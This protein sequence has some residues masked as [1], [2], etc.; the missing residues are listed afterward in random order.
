MNCI[1]IPHVVP[2]TDFKN[3]NLI[4]ILVSMNEFKTITSNC[5]SLLHLNIFKTYLEN[6]QTILIYYQFKPAT[7]PIPFTVQYPDTSTC[8]LITET[9]LDR[10][11]L[12]SH[13]GMMEKVNMLFEN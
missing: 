1:H 2:V 3:K 11:T 12:V 6:A 10:L 5:L 9:F 13:K 8:H 4:I 7:R